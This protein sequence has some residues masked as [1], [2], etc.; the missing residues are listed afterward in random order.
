VNDARALAER[1][2]RAR[3]RANKLGYL[4]CA[5]LVVGSF[6]GFVALGSTSD[7]LA[8]HGTRTTG[9]VTDTALGRGRFFTQHIDVRYTAGPGRRASGRIFVG[10]NDLYHAG[11]QVEILYDPAH[12]SHIRL[13]HDENLR[14]LV[15]VP[16]FGI[17]FGLIGFVLPVTRGR[18]LRAAAD[19]LEAEPER[20]TVSSEVTPYGPLNW[21]VRYVSV[22]GDGVYRGG[23]QAMTA[24]GWHIADGQQI[25]AAAFSKPGRSVVV[26]A[27]TVSRSVA[28][29]GT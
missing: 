4:V 15:A 3:N 21:P 16:V 1:Y 10:E 29:R 11:Q 27:D 24:R 17:L 14:P 12:P 13:V 22:R 19:A 5:G 23:F 2:L 8:E 9:T 6:A 7:W 18:K 25:D 26:V 20:V 28:V